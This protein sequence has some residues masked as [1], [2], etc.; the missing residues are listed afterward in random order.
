MSDIEMVS[1]PK[2]ELERLKDSHERLKA[3]MPL[4]QEARDAITVI[5][6]PQAVLAGLNLTLADRMDDV[7]IA[8]R[9]TARRKRK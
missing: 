8:E 9:W 7:G 2:V 4:F 1:I 5:K 6:H 3:M